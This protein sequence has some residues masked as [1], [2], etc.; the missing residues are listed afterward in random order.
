MRYFFYTADVFTDRIFGG[1]PL[2]VFPEAAGLSDRQ[3]QRVAAEF[4]Y[5]ETVF[6]FAPQTPQGTR[7]L[8]IFTPQTELPFAGH[9]TVGTAFVLAAIA[10]IPL[11]A[12][13]T[14]VCFEEGVGLVPVT[15][16]AQN[17]HPI[18]AELTAAQSPE[19]RGEI[20]TCADLAAMLSL[21][22]EAILNG[23]YAP[24]AVSCGLPF[25]FVPIGDRPTLSRCCL[26]RDRWQSL[27]ADH[28][29][30]ALYVFCP[31]TEDDPIDFHARMF[32]PGMGIAED[33]ATGAAA[34][35]LGGYLGIRQDRDGSF[36][37]LIEQGADMG[38]PSQI[39]VKIERKQGQ[40]QN[41]RVG[42]AS[43]L[44]SEGSMEIPEI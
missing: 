37:W 2:A 30:S 4:N 26:N 42:G 10:Q 19:W 24:Q 5:S 3:M 14:Q 25:L 9:P 17:G 31:G 21:E 43:V 16:Y 11:P 28:W 20:P 44:V 35:A 40:V 36:G 33:P 22:P 15:I 8:R 29:A 39:S 27:L 32:A 1:N 12:P 38:R 23:K 18:F 13:Q 41:I 6:V 34:T 7:Q